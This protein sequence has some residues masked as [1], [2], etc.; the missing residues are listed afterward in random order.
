MT[1]LVQVLMTDLVQ[2]LMTDL[3]QALMTDLVQVLMTDLVQAL[4]TDLVLVL[5]T[6]LVQVLLQPL[7][8]FC[9]FTEALLTRRQLIPQFGS[10]TVKDGLHLRQR[11]HLHINMSV[12]STIKHQHTDTDRY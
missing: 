6:D 12:H 2:A 3:V 8:F 1:D 7:K 11:F 5:M 10:L 4:M 9:S